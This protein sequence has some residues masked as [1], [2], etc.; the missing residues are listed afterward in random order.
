LPFGARWFLLVEE[1]AIFCTL[2][3]IAALLVSI[4]SIPISVPSPLVTNNLRSGVSLGRVYFFLNFDIHFQNFL[5]VY[6]FTSSPDGDFIEN[7]ICMLV[8]GGAL[9]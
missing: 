6:Y 9:L 8:V 5:Q 3:Y 7:S 4:R 2:V 1:Q